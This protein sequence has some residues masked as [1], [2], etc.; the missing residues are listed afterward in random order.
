M[1]VRV[2]CRRNSELVAF[3]S[4]D[5]ERYRAIP[6]RAHHGQIDKSGR[7]YYEHPIGVKLLL[8]SDASQLEIK[9][10]LLHDVLEDTYFDE[11]HLRYW[12]ASDALVT[13]LSWLTKDRS[14]AYLDEIRNLAEFGPREAV[15]V[16]IADNQHNMLPGRLNGST[17]SLQRRYIKSLEILEAALV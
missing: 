14:I 9:A 5:V 12:G 4:F 13:I 6:D 15:R 11:E 7:P 8:P 1:F 3:G 17:K 16:K 2:E 10:A